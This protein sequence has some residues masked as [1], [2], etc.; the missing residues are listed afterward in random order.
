VIVPDLEVVGTLDRIVEGPWGPDPRVADL[1]TGKDVVNYGMAEIPLQLALY[2][3]ASHWWDGQQWHPMIPLDQQRAVVMHV[4]VGQGWCQL[5]EVDIAAG[6]DAVQ[7]AVAVRRWRKRK[8]LAQQIVPVTP[9]VHT[10]KR[11]ETAGTEPVAGQVPAAKVNQQ[12]ADTFGLEIPEGVPGHVPADRVTWVRDR[13]QRIKELGI[14]HV[15]AGLWSRHPDIP[16]FPKGGPTTN[17]HIDVIAA[18]C[19]EAEKA[20]EAPFGP[21]DPTIPPVTNIKKERE[22]A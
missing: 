4:P 6:W 18:M 7:V 5:Y 9:A 15:L 17:H 12:I 3:H 1:K 8:D 16:T 14:G 19:D 10:G 13:V 22:R 20:L 11:P 21:S 2:A